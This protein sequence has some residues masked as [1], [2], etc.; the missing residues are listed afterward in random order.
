MGKGIALT[1]GGHFVHVYQSQDPGGTV[2]GDWFSLENYS[3]ATIAVLKGA[4]SAATITLENA[5]GSGGASNATMAFNYAAEATAAGD[6]LGAIAAA[7]TAGVAI[8]A[9]AGVMVV[10]EVD[11]SELPDG[12]NWM[13]V[14]MS[15]V[16]ASQV[17]IVAILTGPRFGKSESLTAI[18]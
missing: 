15:S 12:S 4:G 11:A 2:T 1:E 17:A 14:K 9:N 3:H 18:A 10:I 13:T 8:S 5:T 7:T 16:T 6:T